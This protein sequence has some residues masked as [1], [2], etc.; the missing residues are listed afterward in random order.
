[1]PE[2]DWTQALLAP[3]GAMVSPVERRAIRTLLAKCET[4][5]YRRGQVLFYEGHVPAGLYIL[6]RGTLA[7]ESAPR[8]GAGGD[9]SVSGTAVLGLGPLRD[10]APY[11]ATARA[12]EECEVVFLDKTLFEDLLSETDSPFGGLF[13]SRWSPGRLCLAGG[14]AILILGAVGVQVSRDGGREFP[15]AAAVAEDHEPFAAGRFQLDVAAS[16]PA[17]AAGWFKDKL[18]VPVSLPSRI[19]RMRLTGARLCWFKGKDPVAYF[20]GHLDDH[21]VSLFAFDARH[22]RAPKSDKLVLQDKEFRVMRQGRYDAVSW[23]SGQTAYLL[24]SDVGPADLL[25]LA[26]DA[27]TL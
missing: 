3:P 10:D 6:L 2:R 24:L 16:E 9:E 11:R 27:K 17:A 22:F 4:S 23:K 7:L 14:L 19:G 8:D 21:A 26:S 1:M 13:K 25:A 18:G 12:R 5:T 20:M 15:I